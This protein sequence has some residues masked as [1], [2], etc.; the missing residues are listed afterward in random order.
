M[1]QKFRNNKYEK[2]DAQAQIA[3]TDRL[4]FLGAV[5]MDHDISARNSLS[6]RV[7]TVALSHRHNQSG[8]IVIKHKTI[9][10]E[11]G[12]SVSAVRDAVGVLKK[13][14]FNVSPVYIDG[15]CVANR[16]DPCW[17]E[18]AAVGGLW[19]VETQRMLTDDEAAEAQK[20]NPV[21]LDDAPVNKD[22]TPCPSEDGPLAPGEHASDLQRTGLC[23]SEGMQN[24]VFVSQG[25]QPSA[26]NPE[27]FHTRSAERVERSTDSRKGSPSGSPAGD[28]DLRQFIAELHTILPEHVPFGDDDGQR[29]FDAERSRRGEFFQLRKL[30]GAGWTKDEVRTMVEA[31]VRSVHDESDPGRGYEPTCKTLSSIFADLFYKTQDQC[32][33]EGDEEFYG[34]RLP[35][36]FLEQEAHTSASNDNVKMDRASGDGSSY[37]GECGP[38]DPF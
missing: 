25:V 20:G 18:A 28:A 37:G 23:S 16:Y 24:S 9:A 38:G 2:N 7:A 3:P 32:R 8:K 30:I 13:R 11:I 15:E 17:D 35:E 34:Q 10:R 31:H 5:A 14:W 21:I 6:A 29:P 4:D 22:D 19:S 36:R 12:C 33:Y 1:S 27:K 26:S